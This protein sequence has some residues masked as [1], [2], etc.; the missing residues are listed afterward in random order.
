MPNPSPL[1]QVSLQTTGEN[2]NQWG[3]VLNSSVFEP[4]EDSI[5]GTLSFDVSTGNVQLVDT[6]G[7]S[8][9]NPHQRFMILRAFGSPQA[10]RDILLP[11]ATNTGIWVIWNNTGDS[12]DV[13]L[14][15]SGQTG[16]TVAAGDIV[17][18]MCDGTDVVP[19]SVT[20]AVSASTAT[21]AVSASELVSIPGADY[22]RLNVGVDVQTF[23]AG[24]AT[25][26]V[27]L[28]YAGTTGTPNLALSNCFFHETTAV[29]TLAA[30]T[31]P[32]D[33]GQF[34]LLVKQGTGSTTGSPHA[35]TFGGSAYAFAAGSAPALTGG[36]G[37][38]DYLAF[39]Y[40]SELTR[41]IGTNIKDVQGV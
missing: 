1:L 2:P 36:V 10:S 39:E 25:A 32:V 15:K 23:S 24:Q 8:G 21:S 41:W 5:A 14:K 34:S 18:C 19:I 3:D 27:T 11:S 4:L 31:N 13:V 17:W 22:A 16:V 40:S 12:S 29:W 20:Q 35:V 9:A 7:A 26:R 28:P 6:I 33:G 38:Y 30:P 37:A